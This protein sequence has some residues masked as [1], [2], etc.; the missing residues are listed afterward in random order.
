[1]LYRF[2]FFFN[3]WPVHYRSFPHHDV[4]L[5]VILARYLQTRIYYLPGTQN[6]QFVARC[7]LTPCGLSHPGNVLKFSESTPKFSEVDRYPLYPHIPVLLCRIPYF[8]VEFS[9]YTSTPCTVP[10]KSGPNAGFTPLFRNSVHHLTFETTAL[11]IIL[12]VY[13]YIHTSTINIIPSLPKLKHEKRLVA[14]AISEPRALVPRLKIS[15]F[16]ESR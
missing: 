8:S 9:V 3:N 12:C 10:L 16:P 7:Y 5:P 14:K 11:L 2:V 1:M 15:F 13:N 6:S 4:D